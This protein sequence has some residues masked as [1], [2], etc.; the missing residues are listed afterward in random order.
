[1]I[2]VGNVIVERADTDV[3]LAMKLRACRPR[4]DLFDLAVLLRH[5]D[6]RSVVEAEAWLDRFS[7]KTR[8]K[9]PPSSKQRSAP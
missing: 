1:V 4:K 5:R 8:S 6:V 3:L 9:T 2:A 7:P